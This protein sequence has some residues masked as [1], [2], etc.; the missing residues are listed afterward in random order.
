ML[1]KII[2]KLS[3]FLLLA[4][5]SCAHKKTPEENL[6]DLNNKTVAV[7]ISGCKLNHENYWFSKSREATHG[8]SIFWKKVG[9]K[10][11]ELRFS[12]YT[13][14]NFIEPGTYEFYGFCGPGVS[15]VHYEY[16]KK[17]KHPSIFTNFSVKG[18]EIVYI[19]NFFID[20][21]KSKLILQAITPVYYKTDTIPLGK[22]GVL[23]D[24]IQK[25]HVK[26]KDSAKFVKKYVPVIE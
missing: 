12:G 13:S 3:I 19:G 18:G 8:C 23:A 25:R 24:K 7:V 26:L 4:L 15:G 17:D 10:S 21:T 5:S 11:D 14:I 2:V 20:V 9:Q 1:N 16:N 6:S 22:Y